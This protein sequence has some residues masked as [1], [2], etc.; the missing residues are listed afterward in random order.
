MSS[1]AHTVL[2]S[3]LPSFPGLSLSS[4]ITPSNQ[5][6]GLGS[7]VLSPV[8]PGEAR[9]PNAFRCFKND[10]QKDIISNNIVSKVAVVDVY[11][12]SLAS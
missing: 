5:L 10:I 4:G 1:P 9:P 6:R 7:A 12:S 2:F 3:S 11:A 8:D